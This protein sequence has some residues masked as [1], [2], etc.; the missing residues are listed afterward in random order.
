MNTHSVIVT[1]AASGIGLACTKLLLEREAQVMAF[2]IQ[3]DRMA[4]V[5]PTSDNLRM[6]AGDVSDPVACE[7]LVAQTISEF[8]QLDALIHWGAAHSSARSI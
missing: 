1:G 5:L 2:D 7:N 6:F 3:G 4:E 8:G